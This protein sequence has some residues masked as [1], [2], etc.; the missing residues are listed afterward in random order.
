VRARDRGGR[1]R[2]RARPAEHAVVPPAG[3]RALT[4]PGVAVW[5]DAAGPQAGHRLDVGEVLKLKGLFLALANLSLRITGNKLDA[6]EFRC[7][8][9]HARGIARCAGACADAPPPRGAGRNAPVSR[10]TRNPRADPRKR[11]A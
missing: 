7:P 8:I 11:L 10:R 1:A 6:V 3:A 4:P 5:Q 2:G 9:P